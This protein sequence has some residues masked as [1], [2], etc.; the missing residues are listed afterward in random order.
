MDIQ[1]GPRSHDS[2]RDMDLN[3]DWRLSK[4]EVRHFLFFLS[5]GSYILFVIVSE[6]CCSCTT[7]ERVPEERVSEA[8]I[9]T[10]WHP[11][12]SDGG[13]HLQKRG[14][15]QRWFYI[16]ERICLSAWWV[17]KDWLSSAVI[18]IAVMSYISSKTLMWP[19]KLCLPGWLVSGWFYRVLLLFFYFFIH[20]VLSCLWFTFHLLRFLHYIQN[21]VHNLFPFPFSVH[22]WCHYRCI[23]KTV[24]DILKGFYDMDGFF[25][26]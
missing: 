11:P 26:F 22:W 5:L 13:W 20:A 6:C 8:W 15:R 21:R 3:D 10:Q 9:C 1:N 25:Y 2:F 16:H 17:L 23:Q 19:E 24:L 18:A 7:G 4:D 12:R 14:W